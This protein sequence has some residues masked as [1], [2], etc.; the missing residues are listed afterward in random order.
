[1]N[2]AVFISNPIT[3][4]QGFCMHNDKICVVC[5]RGTESL[6]DWMTNLKFVLVSKIFF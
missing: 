3:D 4:T 2:G 5:F 6:K 1:M